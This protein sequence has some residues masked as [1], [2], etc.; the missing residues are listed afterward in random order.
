MSASWTLVSRTAELRALRLALDGADI[1]G[2]VLAGPAGVG[3][4]RLATEF[5]DHAGRTGWATAWARAT[6]STATVPFGAFAHLLPATSAPALHPLDLMLRA[7]QAVRALGAD[8]RVVLA[9]DDAHLLDEPSAALVHQL[10]ATRAAFVVTTVRDGERVPDAVRALWKDGLADR[11]EL[12]PLSRDQTGELLAAVLGG[13]VD[14]ATGHR[15]WEASR[16]NVLYL[17][18]VVLMGRQRGA[19]ARRHGVWTWRGEFGGSRRLREL[20]DDRLSGIGGPQRAALEVLAL[21]EP[22]PT[23]MLAGIVG[24]PVLGEL[25]DRGLLA[26]V[27]EGR[28]G[29]VRLAHPLHGE[30]IADGLGTLRRAAIYGQLA[31]AMA[32]TGARRRDDALRLGVWLLES[33]RKADP[34]VLLAAAQRALALFDYP[35]AERLVRNALDSGAVDAV[36]TLGAALHGQRRFDDAARTLAT[37]PAEDAP[38]TAVVEWALVAARNAAVGLADLRSADTILRSAE[39]RL[40]ADPTSAQ[41]TAFRAFVAFLGGRLADALHMVDRATARGVPDVETSVRVTLTKANALV[42]AGRSADAL[43]LAEDTVAGAAHLAQER[44]PLYDEAR[45]ALTAVHFVGGRYAETQRLAERALAEVVVA[46]Q[47]PLHGP[48]ALYSGV[49]SLALGHAETGRRRIRES[50]ASLRQHYDPVGIMGF[51]LVSAAQAAALLGLLDE[52]RQAMADWQQSRHPAIRIYDVWFELAAAWVLAAEGAT[53]EAARRACAAAD[54]AVHQQARMFELDALHLAVRFG[55]RGLAARV[56]DVG[57]AT[58]HAC[59]GAYVEHAAALEARDG[60]RLE[61][62]ALTFA[63]L[64]LPLLAAEAAVEA[65]E[66]YQRLGRTRDAPR[67][68]RRSREWHALCKG[69]RTPVLLRAARG[70]AVQALTVRERELAELAARG[71]SDREIAELLVISPRT[72]GNHLNSVYAKLGVTGRA[73]LAATL[74]PGSDRSDG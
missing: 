16:G 21:G 58:D 8:G 7:S 49:A 18:E 6:R 5:V 68:R 19:L 59:A 4:T 38:A 51:A 40:G 31:D 20:V 29:L 32:A 14:T 69:A 64:D 55:A 13:H 65:A 57:A 62:C 42:A 37:P 53:S 56:A 34:D 17:R 71:L 36:T 23:A 24:G 2:V 72:V 33:G 74:T 12:R 43:R 9:V 63:D 60:D 35:L 30:V 52:A 48:W 67:V 70:P 15:L 50:I 27:T 61:R 47:Q 28:R 39:D 46:G 25:E 26:L 41:V 44:P 54:V 11:V 45:V 3:K 10:A 73:N 22:L 1:A 66:A